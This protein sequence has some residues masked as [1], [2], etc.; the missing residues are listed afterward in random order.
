MRHFFAISVQTDN[1]RHARW[2]GGDAVSSREEHSQ[3]TLLTV[4]PIAEDTEKLYKIQAFIY[5]IDSCL[6]HFS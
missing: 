4:P 2:I 1:I 5:C 6:K 3:H